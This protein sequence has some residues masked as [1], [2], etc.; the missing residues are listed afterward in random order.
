[1]EERSYIHDTPVPQGAEGW[2]EMY[3]HYWTFTEDRADL[4]NKF[5]WIQD[6]L[7]AP[8]LLYPIDLFGQGWWGYGNSYSFPMANVALPT[9]WGVEQRVLNGYLY[10]RACEITDPK[11]IEARAPIFGERA[12][13]IVDNWDELWSKWTDKSLLMAGELEK[14][15]WPELKTIEDWN[16]A[17]P[18]IRA[19]TVNP[20][21]K[22][23]MSDISPCGLVLLQNWSKFMSLI[24]EVWYNH[25]ELIDYTFAFYAMYRMHCFNVFPSIDDKTIGISLSGV[26]QAMI[27]GDLHLR[28]LA[29][30][31][32]EKNIQGIFKEASS[33]EEAFEKLKDSES[34]KEWLKR[35]EKSKFWFHLTTGNA[36]YHFHTCWLDDLSIPLGFLKS[37]IAAKEKGE[38]ILVDRERQ[39][40]EALRVAKEL[41]E[42]LPTEEDKKAFQEVW[43]PARESAVALE[44]HGYFSDHWHF[45]IV[46][47]KLKELGEYLHQYGILKEPGDIRFM[48]LLEI[49]PELVN[50]INS[51]YSQSDPRIKPL[52]DRIE[53]RKN[54]IGVLESSPPPPPFLVGKDAELPDRIT[55]PLM[56]GLWGLTKEKI[57]E[58]VSPPEKVNEIKGWPASSGVYEGPARLVKDPVAEFDRIQPGDVLVTGFFH[59][60]QSVLFSKIKAVVTDG[61]GVMSHPAIVSR[62]YGIPAVVGT[63]IGT[64]NIKDGMRI[65]VDGTEG[66]V[67]LLE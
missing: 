51:W 60:S 12:K 36:L 24:Y 64:R 35:W 15:H 56:I 11:T 57:I 20:G 32:V 25:F 48:H 39:G 9:A 67:T 66:V 54:V 14:I 10:I 21:F 61:G 2:Q 1:M 13:F 58:I 30:L 19:R 6:A 40:K 65:K 8:T 59:A 46:Y 43:E 31:A 49:E 47:R 5:V 45:S 34:G 44:G 62:E 42:L 53:K 23:S 7:H 18:Q 17:G 26:N 37:H 29:D 22:I 55:E 27:E 41:I 63:A 52:Q 4:D 50:L 3:P 28:E 16:V 33:L 38:E